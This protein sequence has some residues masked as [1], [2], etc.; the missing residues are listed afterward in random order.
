MNVR[1]SA[2]HWLAGSCKRRLNQAVV[3]VAFAMA[4]WLCVHHVDAL[5]PD[6]CVSHHAPSPD[7]NPAVLVFLCTKYEPDSSRGSASLRASHGRVVGK[8]RK[9]RPMNRSHLREG[10]F[11]A[12]CVTVIL[13]LACTNIGQFVIGL[14]WCQSTR[15]P[16]ELVPK[17]SV[18]VSIRA[19]VKVMIGVRFRVKA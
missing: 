18:R 14:F 3:C 5:C 9:I 12:F 4:T 1:I 6:N 13:T 2:H 10:S 8:S 11:V 16:S 17:V 15:P 19:R 7:C